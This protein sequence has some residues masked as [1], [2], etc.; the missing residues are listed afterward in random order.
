MN[1]VLECT[2]PF[3]PQYIRRPVRLRRVRSASVGAGSRAGCEQ[4]SPGEDEIVS[5]F[6]PQRAEMDCGLMSPDRGW[7]CSISRRSSETEHLPV[8]LGMDDA[9]VVKVLTV[10][11]PVTEA[12]SAYLNL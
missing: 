3:M 5:P 11:A 4:P 12:A 6:L 9:S 8:K 2:F 1:S 7:E 10:E